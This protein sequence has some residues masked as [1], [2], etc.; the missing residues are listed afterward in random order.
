MF[1]ADYYAAM[2]S[3]FMMPHL[4]KHFLIH[5]QRACRQANLDRRVWSDLDPMES[6]QHQFQCQALNFHHSREPVIENINHQDDEVDDKESNIPRNRVKVSWSTEEEKCL[7]R[8][9]DTTTNDPKICNAQNN[10]HFWQSTTAYFN[11]NRPPG[12]PTREWT[13]IKSHYHWFI[14]DVGKFS[15]WYYNFFNNRPMVK[16]IMMYQSPHMIFG[17]MHTRIRRSSTNT[18]GRLRESTR[19]GLPDHLVVKLIRRRGLP[20]QG[21]IRCVL[22]TFD[23]T[24]KLGLMVYCCSHPNCQDQEV[25][26]TCVGPSLM[27]WS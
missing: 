15:E 25:D 26:K 10:R 17:K 4:L 3:Q 2:G 1:P 21:H 9:C 11:D 19:N 12:M 22:L 20:N 7:V 6:A 24:V 8:A 23:V 16:V 18:C 27:K 5:H 14:L 13:A